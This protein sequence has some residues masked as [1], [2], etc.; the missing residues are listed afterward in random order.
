MSRVRLNLG[1]AGEILGACAPSPSAEP[2]LPPLLLGV[3]TD[4]LLDRWKARREPSADPGRR[5]RPA[6]GA[7]SVNYAR[8]ANELISTSD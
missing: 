6:V 3:Y 5:S 2:P 7:V 1:E 4:R 8:L